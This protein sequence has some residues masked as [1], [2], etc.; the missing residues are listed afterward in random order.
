[1]SRES[2]PSANSSAPPARI[3]IVEDFPI[4]R[5]GLVQL[6][7]GI[8]DF[9]I[10]DAVGDE[11]GARASIQRH[12]PD[13]VLLD[14]MLG[15]AHSLTLIEDLSRENAKLKI[16]VL[17]MMNEAV[18][19]ERALRAGALGY[20]MKTADTDEVL[21]AVRSVLDGRVYLSPRIFVTVF[22]GLLQRSS[23]RQVQGAEGLSDR[24]LQ[25]FQLIGSG[26]PNRQIAT[27]LG[28]SVKTVET[29][30]EHLKS[31]LGL[32]DSSALVHA[33]ELF[34]NSLSA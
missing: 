24:E 25:V 33:A 12:S 7:G 4:V 28:I 29:H 13:L 22:R 10:V 5:E 20:V 11:S 17:S 16:L 18:Y 27:Q 8:A 31:K 30:R 9:R 19:A 23:L 2:E 14:L 21:Q 3:V 15:G 1:M 6:L 32:Q 34:I 26:A